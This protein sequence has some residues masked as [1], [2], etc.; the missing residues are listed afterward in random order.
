M[1][2]TAY[3]L[4]YV[5]DAENDSHYTEDLMR[6]SPCSYLWQ[7]LKEQSSFSRVV[8]V[9]L[10][11]SRL[12]LE[13]FDNASYQFLQ[14]IK[15][16]FLGFGKGKEQPLPDGLCHKTFYPPEIKQED[17]TLLDFLLECQQTH[18]KERTAVV[19]TAE[20]LEVLYERSDTEGRRKLAFYIENRTLPAILAVRLG[21]STIALRKTFLQGRCFLAELDSNIREVLR[22]HA[23]Q[24]LLEMLS[25]Q[26]GGQLVDFS[27]QKGEMVNLLMYDALE[28]GSSPDTPEQLRDQGE[29]LQLCLDA[30]VGLAE[31]F[32]HVPRHEPLKRNTVYGKL[33]DPAFRSRLRTDTARLRARNPES[34]MADLFR[35]EF[36]AFPESG[37]VRELCCED[38]LYRKVCTLI[39][40]EAY[41]KENLAQGRVPEALRKALATLWNKPRNQK[42]CD[43]IRATTD[44]A[45]DALPRKDWVT[46]TDAMNLLSLCTR[47]LCADPVLNDNLDE[48]FATGQELLLA[49]ADL[50]RQEQSFREM[51]PGGEADYFL[52]SKAELAAF[53][54]TQTIL[55]NQSKKLGMLRSSLYDTILYFNDHPLSEQVEQ[56]LRDSMRRWKEKLDQTQADSQ[57]FAGSH[58]ASPSDDWSGYGDL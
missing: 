46:L 28:S 3:Y 19:C 11:N 48:L 24:P 50:N 33:A 31:T 1:F 49:S 39:L 57:L 27:R 29:Y 56:T 25:R 18:K 22:S 45:L 8:F 9:N 55:E 51:Y 43:M 36:R 47:Q 35:R 10:V 12:E 30:G 26:L 42:V 13:T 2:D 17:S 16:G 5:L 37:G 58:P 21:M 34:P 44:A 38:E 54:S 52:M 53:L 6:L 23:Q 20:A 14:P 4:H 7:V 41:L 15:K 40:P 32:A